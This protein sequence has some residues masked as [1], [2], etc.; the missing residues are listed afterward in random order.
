MDRALRSF[1]AIAEFLV[2]SYQEQVVNIIGLMSGCV[3][4]SNF[5]RLGN[6]VVVFLFN[7]K[8]G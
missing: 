8:L 4:P 7:K 6:V 1:S 2:I 5:N 3:Q